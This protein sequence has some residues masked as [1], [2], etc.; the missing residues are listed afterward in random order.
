MGFVIKKTTY[1]P[2]FR[3]QYEKRSEGKRVT[4]DVPVNQWD[5]Y[6][7]SRLSTIEEMR[8][9]VAQLNA[10]DKLKRLAEARFAIEARLKGESDIKCALLMPADVA[11]FE[12]K[13][14]RIRVDDKS[15][16][17]IHWRTCQRIIRDLA[18]DPEEWFELKHFFYEYFQKK[19]YSIN[20][21]PK[22]IGILN[23]WGHFYCRKFKK[24]FLQIPSPRGNV[25]KNINR[26]FNTKL[27]NSLGSKDGNASAPLTPEMLESNRS[28]LSAENYNWLYLSIWLGLRPE[29]I[30]N[31]KT[32]RIERI[33]DD[34][35]L[36]H[37]YQ[38][39][40]DA[41]KTVPCY[42]PEQKVAIEMIDAPMKRPLN[43]T[44]QKHIAPNLTC[45]GGRKN[46]TDMMLRRGYSLEKISLW[47]GH[48]T[49]ERTWRSYKSKTDY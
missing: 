40:V 8:Q 48:K 49:I 22:I 19:A 18:I 43:K 3:L 6:G 28:K 35:T 47:M 11:E 23:Q 9:R 21:L 27:G 44:L 13:F 2:G 33:K 17:S 32:A 25:A 29:E 34:L 45:Y 41:W 30:D 24:P 14:L 12:A 42:L 26:A 31:I 39:K 1:S 46:F 37:V 7:L 10:Q 16:T 15:K 20:Y 38:S 5:H 36:I 4:K